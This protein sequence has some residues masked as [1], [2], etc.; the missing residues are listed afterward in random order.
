MIK[1]NEIPN[2]ESVKALPNLKLQ[3]EYSNGWIG[4]YDMHGLMEYEVFKAL[5]DITLFNSVKKRNN[6]VVW[7]DEIDLCGD[8]IYLELTGEKVAYA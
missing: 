8:A 3:L 7:N 4:T 1:A 5:E 2:L 6:A